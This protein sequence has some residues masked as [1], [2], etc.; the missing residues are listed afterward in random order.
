MGNGMAVGKG[1]ARQ[2]NAKWW[3]RV[4]RWRIVRWWAGMAGVA[5]VG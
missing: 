2:G 4:R 3:A 1:E 5:R